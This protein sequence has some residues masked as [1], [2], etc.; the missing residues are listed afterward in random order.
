VSLNLCALYTLYVYRKDN[1]SRGETRL[2]RQRKM[3]SGSSRSSRERCAC[4]R[5]MRGREKQPE[6][7]A[8]DIQPRVRAC[9]HTHDLEKT[10]RGAHL[11]T[12]VTKDTAEMHSPKRSS[13]TCRLHSK[14]PRH[15][16]TNLMPRVA[17]SMGCIE[18]EK[19]RESDEKRA[20]AREREIVR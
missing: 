5:A 17:N 20:R 11:H 7:R 14:S 10:H 8:A 3:S 2:Q 1:E 15:G 6:S 4:M 16:A 18:G 13:Q 12:P 9:T 19:A